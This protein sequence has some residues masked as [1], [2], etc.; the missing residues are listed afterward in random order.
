MQVST[1]TSRM[2]SV[3]GVVSVMV[4]PGKDGVMNPCPRAD[5]PMLETVYQYLDP[6]RPVAAEM[7]VIA[8]EYVG[9]GI[10]V[11]VEVKTGYGLLQVSQAVET[12][13]RSYLWP[14]APG[15]PDKSGWP[16]GRG[17]R[18]LELEVIVSQV[19]GVMEVNGL[20]LFQPLP[21]GGYQ[22][23]ATGSNDAS[24]L[25]LDSWQLPEALEVTV[26]AGPDGSGIEAPTMLTP[27]P[28]TD[29]TVA[30]PVVPT[31]C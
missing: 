8:S 3:P 9:L 20:N 6:R 31:V 15:G 19:P 13:L 7:Y 26:A 23:L 11:A 21:A 5:R 17:V 14:I 25:T 4:I 1:L 10:S 22:Q 29:T 18:S 12:A 28:E 27:P 16:L 30:V 2:R 24:E